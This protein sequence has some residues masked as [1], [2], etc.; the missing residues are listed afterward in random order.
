[1]DGLGQGPHGVG[2]AGG[3]FDGVHDNKD[4]PRLRRFVIPHGDRACY[5]SRRCSFG[6]HELYVRLTGNDPLGALLFFRL[7]PDGTSYLSGE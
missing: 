6:T 3:G 2:E 1:M 4:L 5:S 7:S